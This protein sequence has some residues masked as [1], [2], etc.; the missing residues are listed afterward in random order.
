[1]SDEIHV[2]YADVEALEANLATAAEAMD[3]LGGRRRFE[4]SPV[5]VAAHEA[6]ADRWDDRRNALVESLTAA[7][8]TLGQVAVAF[9]QVDD[10]LAESAPDIGGRVP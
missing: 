8:D 3:A 10:G 5:V 9:R 7:A 6:L 2:V 1:M 4:L